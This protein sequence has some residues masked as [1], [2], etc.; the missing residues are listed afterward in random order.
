VTKAYSNE[1]ILLYPK[2]INPLVYFILF[3]RISLDI[4]RVYIEIITR[5]QG[6]RIKEGGLLYN[7]NL[8]FRTLD[9]KARSL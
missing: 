9:I 2:F 6:A 4:N 8:I 5:G 1:I 3:I 7:F